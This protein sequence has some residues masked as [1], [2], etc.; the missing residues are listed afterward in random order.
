MILQDA[1]FYYKT[2]RNDIFLKLKSVE[3]RQPILY[4]QF[5]KVTQKIDFL[6]T[7]DNFDYLISLF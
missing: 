4:I 1:F 3:F 7:A 5:R 2:D 6:F